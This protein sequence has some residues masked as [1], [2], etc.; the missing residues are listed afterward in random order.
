MSRRLG[1]DGGFRVTAMGPCRRAPSVHVSAPRSVD[2]GYKCVHMTDE[3]RR[4]V[5]GGVG[6]DGAARE[7][8]DGERRR[9]VADGPE[10]DGDASGVAV[11]ASGH[12]RGDAWGGASRGGEERP[13][14]AAH[15]E[16]D[17]SGEQHGTRS[18][19]GGD[20]WARYPK[21]PR[22][23]CRHALRRQTF[24]QP[25]NNGKKTYVTGTGYGRSAPQ[26]KR[27]EPTRA[28]SS[29]PGRARVVQR[30]HGPIRL[31]VRPF[32]SSG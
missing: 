19:A 14:G 31:R 2:A 20:G 12:D 6:D 30:P 9:R 7:S 5:P 21:N 15:R 8:P 4:D 10:G 17:V 23:D 25:A 13:R 22:C 16:G 3:M 24:C 18:D 28:G 32:P 26:S 27:R 29:V 1:R 11:A